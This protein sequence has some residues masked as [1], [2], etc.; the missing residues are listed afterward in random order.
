MIVSRILNILATGIA[1]YNNY[2]LKVCLGDF[3]LSSFIKITIKEQLKF[4]RERTLNPESL[5]S[6]HELTVRCYRANIVCGRAPPAS[7]LLY[8]ITVQNWI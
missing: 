7:C 1:T 8:L 4:K 3:M 2:Y 6:I 5:N